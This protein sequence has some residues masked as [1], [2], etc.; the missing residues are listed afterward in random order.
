MYAR[1]RLFCMLFAGSGVA[2]NAGCETPGGPQRA[3]SPSQQ[4]PSE[5]KDEAP[6]D[7]P[8]AKIEARTFIAAG[9]L[10]ESQNRLLPAIEQYRHALAEDPQNVHILAKLGVLYDTVGNGAEAEKVYL[11]AV[12]LDPRS[13][14]LHNNLAFS[15]ILRQRWEDAQAALAQAIDLKPDFARARIN[16][17]MVLSQTNRFDDA[18]R[19]FQMVLPPDEAHYNLGLMYQSKRR[20]VEAAES[21]KRA[22]ALNPKLVAAQEQLNRMPA[23]VLGAADRR[24]QEADDAAAS[25][26]AARAAEASSAEADQAATQPA[27]DG[28]SPCEPVAGVNWPDDYLLGM[29]IEVVPWMC[30]DVPEGPSVVLQSENSA[31]QP[32]QVSITAP[33]EEADA[34]QTSTL[35]I[36]RIDPTDL[37]LGFLKKSR[38]TSSLIDPQFVSLDSLLTSQLDLLLPPWQRSPTS[39]E[40]FRFESLRYVPSDDEADGLDWQASPPAWTANVPARTSASQIVSETTEPE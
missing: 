17:A 23:D 11:Q 3:T 19:Q 14:L 9:R 29:M 10:H 4:S 15:Y 28:D 21:Y 33:E 25:L 24:I 26:A 22:I 27:D 16:M 8:P 31:T 13:A 34:E 40:S 5:A 6:A 37:D 18:M 32:A 36:D 39:I 30:S 1:M 35:P 12:E 20:S 38:S 2:F 7:L